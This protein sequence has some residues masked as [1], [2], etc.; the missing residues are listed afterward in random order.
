MDF[1][2]FYRFKSI[3]RFLF[4]VMGILPNRLVH[5]LRKREFG[6]IHAHFGKSGA[7]ALPLSRILNLPLIVTYHGADATKRSHTDQNIFKKL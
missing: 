4:H 6:V 5:V 1:N 7:Y 2:S 3:E